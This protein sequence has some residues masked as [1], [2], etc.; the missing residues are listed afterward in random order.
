MSPTRVPPLMFQFWAPV[1][2]SVQVE[3]STL[4]KTEK[5]WYCCEGPMLFTL[6]VPAPVPP[7]WKMSLPVPSTVPLMTELGAS[8]SV[9]GPG[10]A[11][12]LI[13][14]P[15]LMV[16]ELKTL[17]VPERLMPLLM[18][19]AFETVVCALPVTLKV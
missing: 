1:P 2:V 3:V 7:S 18:V 14:G 11:V 15:P 4:L 6:K 10:P 16:P 17:P 9:N 13:A 12:K 19:P 8:V 5:P